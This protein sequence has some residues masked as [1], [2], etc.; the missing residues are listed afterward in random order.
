MFMSTQQQWYKMTKD[1]KKTTDANDAPVNKDDDYLVKVTGHVSP[2]SEEHYW[3][4]VE[5]KGSLIEAF[6]K[7]RTYHAETLK[8]EK[9]DDTTYLVAESIVFG[10]VIKDCGG[11]DMSG[12]GEEPPEDIKKR[13]KILYEDGIYKKAPK[14]PSQ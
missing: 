8:F 12:I 9:K 6:N 1:K 2:E 13:V 5:I 10:E 7:A 11:V 4:F 3:A 14:P